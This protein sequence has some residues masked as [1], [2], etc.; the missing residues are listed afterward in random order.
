MKRNVVFGLFDPDWDGGDP[1]TR[2][3]RWRPTV[4]VLANSDFPVARFILLVQSPF[5]DQA[6]LAVEDMQAASPFSEIELRVNSFHDPWDF[7][8]VYAY[9]HDTIADY[10]FDIEAE[11]YYAHMSAGTHV[12]RICLYLLTEARILP[13]R[14]LQS[15]PAGVYGEGA[16]GGWRA[17]D[18]DLAKYDRLA[19]RFAQRQADGQSLLK[20]GIATRNPAFNLLIE[21]IEQV[22]IASRQPLLLTGPTGAGKTILATR[23][24]ELKRHRHQVAGDFVPVNCATL[25]GDGAMSALFGHRKGAFTGAAADRPGLLRQ[26]DEG[27]LFLDEIG[28]LGLEEQAMLLTAVEKGRYYPVGADK[29]VASRF[30]L[31]AGTNRDL[32][33]EIAAGRFRDDLY[34]RINLWQFDL[35]SLKGRPEDIEPNLDHELA[36]FAAREGRQVS[37]NR[38]A[39]QRYLAF[40]MASEAVWPGNFRDLNASV[41]RMATLA[42]GGRIGAG[43]VTAEIAR[44]KRAWSGPEAAGL[45]QGLVDAEALAAIDPFDRLQL[46]QVL[47]V[48]RES[49]S[50]ADAGRRLYSVSRTKRGTVNDSDRL[51]KYLARFDLAWEQIRGQSK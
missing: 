34:S 19:R 16:E 37:F 17:I 4:S 26:A 36:K 51:R 25:R 20:S 3:Q 15:Y 7:E 31:I 5:L 9:L 10:P 13:G 24:Y 2:C 39:R 48:C 41:T 44:L 28:E 47:A 46:E 22:A 45:L 38:D 42:R 21:E 33:H 1:A 30:Q 23:I 29:E 14:M 6:R 12:M 49:R 11:D 8:E 43:E 27:V 50:L 32:R 40:A 18:L 35:P